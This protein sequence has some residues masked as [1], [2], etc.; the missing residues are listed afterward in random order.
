MESNM[1]DVNHLDA[2]V[3][4]PPRKRLLAGFIKQTSNG[5]RQSSDGNGRSPESNGPVSQMASHPP[6]ISFSPTSP[7]TSA[8]SE[9][10]TLV[11]DLMNSHLKNPNMS[12][13][14][15]VEVSKSAAASATK[16]AKIA[17][18]AAQRKAAIASK[19]IAAAKSALELVASLNEEATATRDGT[20]RKNKMKKHVPVQQLYKKHQPVE[21]SRRT[22]EE[23]AHRLHRAMNSSPRISKTPPSLSR[24]KQKFKGLLSS[25]ERLGSNTISERISVPKGVLIVRGNASSISNYEKTRVSNGHSIADNSGSDRELVS[26]KPREK[27]ST[28]EAE[29]SRSKDKAKE[30]SSSPGRKRGRAKLKKLSLKDQVYPEEEMI[31]R[32]SPKNNNVCNPNGNLFSVEPTRDGMMMPVE[33]TPVWKYQEFKAPACVKQNKVLQS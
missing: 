11:E 25:S 1:C 7:S 17:R 21:N 8:S 4:L 12:A 30:D 18:A 24:K 5:N 10:D 16:D 19:A 3:R 28:W 2:D 6:M 33:A 14:E 23:L 15:L 9:I 26:V 22:D 31:I 27:A 20:L 29:S 13:E 32:S